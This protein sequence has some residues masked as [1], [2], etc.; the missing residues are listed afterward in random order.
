MSSLEL[1]NDTVGTV[2][3]Q[4]SPKPTRAEIKQDVVAAITAIKQGPRAM[5]MYMDMCVKCGTCASVCP[6]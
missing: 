4:E 6:V 3:S 5:Q 2:E 1:K